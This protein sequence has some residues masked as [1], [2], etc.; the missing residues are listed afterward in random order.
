MDKIKLT[1]DG[2]QVKANE[3]TTILEAAREAKRCLQ[4]A[5]RLQITPAPLPPAPAKR[6]PKKVKALV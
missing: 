1:I 3:G 2:K 5:F 4:C 6:R